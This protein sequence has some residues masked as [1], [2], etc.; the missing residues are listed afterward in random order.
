VK[1]AADLM[2]NLNGTSGY[3][4]GCAGR[5]LPLENKMKAIVG[6]I[7]LTSFTSRADGSVGF[8]GVTPELSS[9]EKCALFDLQNKNCRALFE[10]TDYSTDGKIEIKNPLGTKSPSERLR[11]VLFVLYKQLCSSGK[12]KDK[13]YD[14]F[15]V[16]QLESVINSYKEQLEPEN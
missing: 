3:N 2:E 4:C 11:G 5:A 12:L 8:R 15:Y 1:S 13:T 9:L 16:E 10:P 14:T 7:I 6:Q